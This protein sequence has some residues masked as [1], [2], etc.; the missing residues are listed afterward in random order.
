MSINQFR[1]GLKSVSKQ[2]VIGVPLVPPP[3]G[4]VY[5]TDSDGLYLRDAAGV[6]LIGLA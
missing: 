2:S 1:I 4:Y 6:Y 3:L 5:L